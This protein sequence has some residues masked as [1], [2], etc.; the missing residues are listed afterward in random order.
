MKSSEARRKARL[1]CEELDQDGNGE[2]DVQELQHAMRVA[3]KIDSKGKNRQ[4]MQT[5]L[6]PIQRGA[7]SPD[8]SVGASRWA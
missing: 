6:A 7:W 4:A 5:R 1:V 3:A 8:K 2:L